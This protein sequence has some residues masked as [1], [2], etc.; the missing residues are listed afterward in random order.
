MNKTIISIFA[1]AILAVPARAVSQD[2]P[3]TRPSD[4]APIEQKAVESKPAAKKARPNIYDEKADA[5]QQIA[6]ALAKAK[7]ENQRVLIQWG[8]NWCGWCHLLHDLF[9]SDAKIARELLYEYNV[10]LV[11]IGNWDKN[12]DVAKKYNVDLKGTGVPYLTILDAAEKVL[13]NEETSPL[14]KKTAEGKDGHDPE[15]VLNLLKKHEAQPLSAETVLQ[16]ALQLAK[17]EDKAVFLHFGAP[18]CGWCR[19]LEAWMARPDVAGILAKDFID[20]K[21]DVDRMVGGKDA[22]AKYCKKDGG[23]PWF[24]FVTKDGAAITTSDSPKGNVGCPFEPAEI[25]WFQEMLKK[26]K[27][28]ITDADIAEL[29]RTLAEEKEKLTKKNAR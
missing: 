11:D 24:V 9:K 15:K 6:A 29:G 13:A 26:A 1:C 2:V 16:D 18:W 25:V 19:R 7:A 20:T 23:L 21:I 10:V 17:K 22:I 4:G 28:K 5:T 27:V 14:E 8:A 3:A 12:M